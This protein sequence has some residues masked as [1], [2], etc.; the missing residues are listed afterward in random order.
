MTAVLDANLLVVAAN[1][2]D[3][4]HGA[5]IR[6]VAAWDREGADLHAPDLAPYEFASALTRLAALAGWPADR[7]AA[8]WEVFDHLALTMHPIGNG[9]RVVTLARRLGRQSAYDAAYIALAEQLGAELWTLDRKLAA[10]AESVGFPV[11]VV[12]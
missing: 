12:V 3:A 1:P 4:H 10:N 11:R 7:L 5:V 6:R 9:V 2:A 8:A